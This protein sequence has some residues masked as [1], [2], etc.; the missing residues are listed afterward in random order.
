MSSKRDNIDFVKFLTD[1]K[2]IEWLLFQSEEMNLYWGNFIDQH[3]YEIENIESAKKHLNRI[4]FSSEKLTQDKKQ[5]AIE[6]LKQ[7]I[8]AYNRK[9]RI[10]R[11]SY[12]AAVFAIL[13]S[14]VLHFQKSVD[15]DGSNEAAVEYITGNTL[16]SE[17][18]LFITGKETVSFQNNVDIHIE[19][20]NTAQIS[21]NEEFEKKEIAIEQSEMNKLIVPFGKRSSVLLS[22]GTKVWLNSGST[23]EFPSKF[24]ENSREVYLSGEMYFEVAGD[25]KRAFIVHTAGYTVKVLGTEFNINSFDDNSSH[26]VLVNG[27]LS[28]TTKQNENIILTPNE[29]AVF[30]ENTG[31]FDT[32]KV[33]VTPFISWKEGYL[34][35]N[36]TPAIEVLK[37][38]ERYYNLSLDYDEGVSFKGITCT[39]KIILSENL[40][41]VMTTFSTLSSTKY[42]RE[43]KQ[44][45]L[46][47]EKH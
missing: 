26:V 19:N 28:L 38:I 22:D 12:A 42:I 43:E 34:T 8:K 32:H 24:S 31:R 23:L 46:Y 15:Q 17:S 11:F 9:R 18:I 45:Y 20:D 3:P 13:V 39:G 4:M 1:D 25:N 14:L 40:D 10:R 44:I 30:S 37:Q 6:K 5:F 21:S 36:D 2:F 16:D 47:K 41:Q 35:F 33:D 27:S 29:Q 7:S